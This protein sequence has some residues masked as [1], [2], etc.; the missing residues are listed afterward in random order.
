MFDE[1]FEEL[2][3]QTRED[4]NAS[5]K[6]SDPLK[7]QS[8]INDSSTQK[9]TNRVSS[10]RSP[11]KISSGVKISSPS[12]SLGSHPLGGGDEPKK[13]VSRPIKPLDSDIEH[14]K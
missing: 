8:L 13:E 14:S 10:S 3:A 9:Q 6:T 12:R 11:R 5:R 1:I 4:I 2:I 7:R